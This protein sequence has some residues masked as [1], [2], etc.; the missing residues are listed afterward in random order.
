[1]FSRLYTSVLLYGRCWSRC[2]VMREWLPRS[3]FPCGPEFGRFSIAPFDLC[4]FIFPFFIF[5]LFSINPRTMSGSSSSRSSSRIGGRGSGGGLSYHSSATGRI[6]SPRTRAKVRDSNGS[7][8]PPRFCPYCR[9]S[10]CCAMGSRS[11][12]CILEWGLRSFPTIWFGSFVRA[13]RVTGGGDHGGSSTST[14]QRG[15]LL[16]STQRRKSFLPS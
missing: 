8:L 4:H 7:L 11:E 5:H 10:C 13:R 16:F 6:V 2:C 3:P 14:F 15:A 1:M 9:Q 12:S